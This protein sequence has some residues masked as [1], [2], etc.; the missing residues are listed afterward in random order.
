MI[1]KDFKSNKPRVLIVENDNRWRQVHKKNLTSWGCQP[2]IALGQGQSLLDD[3]IDKVEIYRCHL[4]IVDM[5]LINHDSR[6]DRSGLNLL[7]DLQP[8]QSIIVSGY[9][10]FIAARTAFIEKGA[11]HFIGK[12]EGPE[13]LREVIK[14]VLETIC[15]AIKKIEIEWPAGLSAQ[16]IVSRLLPDV[17]DSVPIDQINDALAL[18]FPEAKHIRL[19]TLDG[20]NDL[21]QSGPRLHSV[22]LKVYV[23]DFIQPEIIKIATPKDIEAQG[24]RYRMHVDGRLFGSFYSLLKKEVC[25]WDIGAAKYDFLSAPNQNMV[26][27]AQLYKTTT[28]VDKLVEPLRFFFDELWGKYYQENQD[29]SNKSLFNAYCS[30]WGTKWWERLDDF[31]FTK[32]LKIPDLKEKVLNPVRWLR[33]KMISDSL[34]NGEIP[35]TPL[36]ITH[37][38]LHGG[39]LF[40][41][42]RRAWVI[43]FE[44]TGPGPIYQDFAEFEVNM[45]IQ[46]VPI[47]DLLAFSQFI[48]ILLEI[49]SA[50]QIEPALLTNQ[51]AHKALAVI[52][53]IRQLAEKKI[54]K[55]DMEVYMWCML[56]D[57]LFIVSLQTANSETDQVQRNRALLL[58]GLICETLDK[59]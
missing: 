17:R 35:S 54:T 34:A 12:E 19:Q 9:A 27:W 55:F 52:K 16:A 53:E 50:N 18:L 57:T 22:V 26:T 23:D 29:R 51:D 47:A 3:A 46:L 45:M 59:K 49:T 42:E 20:L 41:H 44:R 6:S 43:D 39:N 7:P 56:F 11:K 4:A 10:D 14:E 8:A 37:G 2:V 32:Y 48:G 24:E 25:L 30:V 28:S 15:A 1:Q 58:G 38:D 21:P 33:D 13:L 36:A 40:V 31:S 5:K